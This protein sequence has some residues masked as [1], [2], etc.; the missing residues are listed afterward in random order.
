MLALVG[1]NCERLERLV[2]ELVQPV[3]V[4]TATGRAARVVRLEEVGEAVRRLLRPFAGCG[5]GDAQ[6]EEA[7][8]RIPVINKTL[9]ELTMTL[10]FGTPKGN[11]TRANGGEVGSDGVNWGVIGR[12]GSLRGFENLDWL[13]VSWVVLVGWSLRSLS[14]EVWSDETLRKRGGYLGRVLPKSLRRLTITDEMASWIQWEWKPK[15]MVE[16]TRDWLHSEEITLKVLVWKLRNLSRDSDGALTW[17]ERMRQEMRSV[18]EKAGVICEFDMAG[19][20][21]C[22]K[23]QD[24][25]RGSK[26]KE[27]KRFLRASRATGHEESLREGMHTL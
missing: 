19:Y 21:A 18:C 4:E 14:K 9:T 6:S 23:C 13:H 10:D 11:I 3:T 8:L 27:R 17:T 22:P 15:E 25:G 7:S 24:A 1:R 2:V 20:D 12:L 5:V 16:L 26:Y